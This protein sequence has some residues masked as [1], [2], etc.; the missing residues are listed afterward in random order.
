MH[1]KCT[2]VEERD[3]CKNLGK[4]YVTACT[5]KSP[6]DIKVMIQKSPLDV[7][8]EL[9]RLGGGYVLGRPGR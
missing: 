7:V 4:K 9:R 2:Q 5:H 6:Y 3:G 1:S 8:V